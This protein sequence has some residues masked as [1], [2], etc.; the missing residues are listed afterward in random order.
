[1]TYAG[2]GA[3]SN[4]PGEF[5]SLEH[6]GQVKAAFENYRFV[7]KDGGTE[8]QIEMDVVPEYEQFMADTR[9]Q[10]PGRT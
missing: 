7:H 3:A 9:P 5:V 1:L 10:G 6:I 2:Q 4:R 8:G